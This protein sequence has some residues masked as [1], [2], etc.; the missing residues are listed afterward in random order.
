MEGTSLDCIKQG[1]NRKI[2][3]YPT[4]SHCSVKRNQ[5]EVTKKRKWTKYVEGKSGNL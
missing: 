2:Q 3:E 1:E 5:F 4:L